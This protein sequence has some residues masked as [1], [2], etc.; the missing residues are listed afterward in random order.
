M[1]AVSWDVDGVDALI[2][3]LGATDGRMDV[4]FRHDVRD[5]GQDFT[6]KWRKDAAE[7]GKGYAVHY[8]A[9]IEPELIDDGFGVVVGPLSAHK[10]GK[11]NFEYGS[12]AVAGRQSSKWFEPPILTPG[13]WIGG[14]RIGQ[15]VGQDKPHMSMNL[16]ADVEFPRFVTRLEATV[17][18]VWR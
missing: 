7:K 18:K 17:A 11:M 5:E 13:G 8:V 1:T 15:R 10:Q 9:A 3:D 4:A 12:P 14:P 2:A 16:T 6:S